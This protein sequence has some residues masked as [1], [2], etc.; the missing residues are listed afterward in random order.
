LTRRIQDERVETA[1]GRG[2]P[3]RSDADSREPAATARGGLPL[4]GLPAHMSASAFSLTL[5]IPSEG[6]GIT[7]GDPVIGGAHG[8]A[9][10]GSAPRPPR[11]HRCRHLPDGM[12]RTFCT[13]CVFGGWKL[14]TAC[15]P[16]PLRPPP[17]AAGPSTGGGRQFNGREGRAL[18]RRVR[19]PLGRRHG[20]P[21]E[22]QS[23]RDIVARAR[24][25]LRGMQQP[26]RRL[27]FSHRQGNLT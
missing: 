26:P 9:L 5:A 24:V 12:R 25:R 21:L 27:G 7:A 17:P 16:T 13:D 19:R 8:P 6:F 20:R 23:A 22:R 10:M 14:P 1:L 15:A 2:V 4:H 11:R 18:L 3:L